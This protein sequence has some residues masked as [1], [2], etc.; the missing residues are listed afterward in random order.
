LLKLNRVFEFFLR[1]GAAKGGG[2]GWFNCKSDDSL[3]GLIEVFPLLFIYL[4]LYA[5][6]RKGQFDI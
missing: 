5:S 2:G 1:A 4:F 3:W 6:T